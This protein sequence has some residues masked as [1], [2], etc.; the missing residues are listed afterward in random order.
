MAV[1]ISLI[2]S[3]LALLLIT[4]NVANGCICI[5]TPTVGD[6]YASADAVFIGSVRKAEHRRPNGEP[7][8]ILH[9]GQIVHVQ[10]ERVFKG[11]GMSKAIFHAGLSSCDSIYEEGQRWLFYAY[12]DKKGRAWRIHDCDRSA[13]IENAGG[14]LHYLQRLPLPTSGETTLVWGAIKHYE[15]DPVKGGASVKS[16]SGVKVKLIAGQKTYEI[17]TDRNGVYSMYGLPPG[18]YVIRPETPPGLKFR[19][20]GYRGGID[21]SDGRAPK[22]TLREKSFAKVDFV[23][24]ADTSTSGNVF[25]VGGPA[26]RR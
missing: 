6:A 7:I 16:L 22:V 3:S 11:K 4:P 25:G 10:V 1:K 14:D 9:S 24:G 18:R 8:E 20:S 5:F 19:Y 15:N 2:A 17:Y 26:K 12:Y 21:Y 23:F 13:L